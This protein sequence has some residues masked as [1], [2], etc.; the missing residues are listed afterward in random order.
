VDVRIDNLS[1]AY[2]S[3][4]VL[5]GV[6]AD[7]PSGHVTAVI[8]PNGAGKST[9]LRLMLGVLTPTAGAVLLGGRPVAGV[10]VAE[11]ARV[12]AYIPQRGEVAFPFSAREV[13]R[14]GRY[15]AGAGAAEVDAALAAVGLAERADEPF[16]VLSAGQ[17]QRVTVARAL[18]QLAG[19]DASVLLCDE[20]VS[21]MDPA[22]TLRTMGLLA[23]HARGG[24]T[25]V[26]VLHDLSLVLRF[27][28][29]V[30]ALGD[31]GA[32]IAEGPTATTLTPTT[33][34]RAF[35]IEFKALLDGDH[36]AAFVPVS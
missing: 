13:V 2:T 3:R 18:A 11:R 19:R 17:Q 16:G 21:A 35:G 6:N 12:I 4:P 34:R 30:L 28:S 33:L 24:G 9:L 20:P 15:A 7:V 1:F 29:R 31:D 36:L 5:A 10:P 23:D 14:L 32:A 22:H 8:G 25:V 27:A 26:V